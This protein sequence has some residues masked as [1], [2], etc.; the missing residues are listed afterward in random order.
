MM[1]LSNWGSPVAKHL[2]NSV[3]RPL[4][5]CFYC[6]PIVA[7]ALVTGLLLYA[8]NV[9]LASRSHE[10]L[11]N[12]ETAL[13][14]PTRRYWTAAEHQKDG[15]YGVWS[16]SRWHYCHRRSGPWES[17]EVQISGLR[18]Q[19][20]RWSQWGNPLAHERRMR[21]YRTWATSFDTIMQ[22]K[23]KV[24]LT[25]EDALHL[26]RWRTHCASAYLGKIRERARC[27]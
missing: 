3:F 4:H 8:D 26:I 11:Q 18:H 1:L 7:S 19:L 22:D 17:Y 24:S 21:Y 16:S 9:F 12:P 20:R 25:M 15:N 5:R 14:R 10:E 27:N 2:V 23:E 6:R 13:E